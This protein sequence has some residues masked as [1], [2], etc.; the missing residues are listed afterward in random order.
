MDS[1]ALTLPSFSNNPLISHTEQ[2]NHAIHCIFL[3][4]HNS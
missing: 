3:S 1:S 4:L 2:N